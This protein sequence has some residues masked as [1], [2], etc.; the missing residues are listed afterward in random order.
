MSI[1]RKILSVIA[2]ALVGSVALGGVSASAQDISRSVYSGPAVSVAT[3]EKAIQQ[4]GNTWCGFTCMQVAL[5]SLGL[6]DEILKGVDY[7]VN[8]DNPL[9]K[10]KQA[11]LLKEHT[12]QNGE[13]SN[14]GIVS[15]MAAVLNNY[16]R[17][18][19]LTKCYYRYY[20][21]KGQVYGDDVV[22]MDDIYDLK[23]TIY[24]S[25][26]NGRPVICRLNT[27]YLSYYNKEVDSV[28]YVVIDAIDMQRNHVGI[29]DSY[30]Y[31]A[32]GSSEWDTT[33]LGKRTVDLEEV[34]DAV[35]NINS[36]IIAS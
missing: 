8:E 29:V 24:N 20:G 2:S 9:D 12:A 27:Y 33:Y 19:T 15:V 26:C 18:S 7:T 32:P 14:T 30:A 10:I 25:L 34:Y 16:I 1:K 22:I 23:Q 28:H 36:L 35:Y 6:D 4:Y 31:K 11:Q 13:Y 3:P 17:N 21:F 5:W